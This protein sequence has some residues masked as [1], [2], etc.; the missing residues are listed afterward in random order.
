MA[1][2]PTGS[3][4]AAI[5]TSAPASKHKGPHTSLLSGLSSSLND[6]DSN[7]R[8][9]SWLF[10]LCAVPQSSGA[11]TSHDISSVSQPLP[12]S[13][14]PWYMA[15]NDFESK[16][17]G[18]ILRIRPAPG[19]LTVIIGKN[20]TAAYNILFRTTDSRYHPSWAVTTLFIPASFYISPSGNTAMLSYQ[21]AYNS[22][23][24]DSSPS[25][26]LYY[27]MA[28][29][30]PDLG[31]SSSTS[32]IN[33]LLGQGW[34]VN[35]PDH[36]GPTA[37]FGASVQAGHA[38]LDAVR[39][40]LNLAQ[41]TGAANFTAAIWGYC[42]GSIATE[43][44]AE[45]QV[46]YAPELRLCAAVLGGLVDD[47]SADFELINESP[48]AG[49]LVAVLL[50]VT[51]QY[52]EAEAYLRSR[53]RPETADEFLRVR[54]IDVGE[55]VKFFA[56]RDVFSYFIGGAADLQAPVLRKVYNVEM[57]LG[58]HGVPA[59]PMFLYKAIGDQFCPVSQT[60]ALVKKFCDVGVDITYERNTVGG[61]VAEIENGKARAIE[62]LW[63][64][65]DESHVPSALRH[66]VKDVTLNFSPLTT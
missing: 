33:E 60:D 12:P 42:G 53:L 10:G 34:I 40:V 57:K 20:A 8:P 18:T 43:A 61:H 28:Q 48:I 4:P 17:S 5:P 11:T 46:Q 55:T 31:I 49:A 32:L 13:Q 16:N 21:F 54:D 14:D 7:N 52:P 44:A 65:F 6:L 24:L 25:Y 1:E 37:A 58:Y 59:M 15:P 36:E 2:P 22:A 66:T 30:N 63:S 51:A 3:A 19:N 45:L 64:I 50:G 41:L 39:A 9:L 47:F 26:G 27:R 29:S 35:T 38:T 23:N 62:W 56:M